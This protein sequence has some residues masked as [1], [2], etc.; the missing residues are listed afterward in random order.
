MSNAMK[1][2][3]RLMAV[4][5]I[6]LA[7]CDKNKPDTTPATLS[8]DA[9]AEITFNADGTGG[10][11]A[12]VVTTNQ[13][14]WDYTLAPA[15]G[16]GWL[17]AVKD[18]S[19]LKLTAAPNTQ[20]TAPSPVTITFRAGDAPEKTTT[21]KQLAAEEIPATLS[22]DAP[23]EITFNAD[24]TGEHS[25]ITVTTNQAEWNF[26]LT[27]EEGWLTAE[28]AG[29]TLSLT[30]APNT[31]PVTVEDVILEFTAGEAEPVTLTVKQE[32][33]APE[34]IF[35]EG[36]TFSMGSSLATNAP[37]NELPVRQVTLSDFSIGKFEVTQALWKAVL[38]DDASTSDRRGDDNLPIEKM[39]YSEV[40]EFL[41]AL[42][43]MTGKNYRLPTEAEWEYAAKGGK[44]K[45]AFLFSGSDNIDE[46]AW[47]M[48]NSGDSPTT[49]TTHPVGQKAPNS[50]GIYDMTGNVA[51]YVSDWYA[52]SYLP[53]DTDNP[54][55]P[56]MPT[57]VSNQKKVTRGGSYN[58]D[59]TISTGLGNQLTNTGRNSNW[60]TDYDTGQTYIGFRLVLPVTE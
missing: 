14:E 1:N 18:G 47:Y 34:M 46:V 29:N 11:S 21:V 26:T 54:Q 4:A 50:L 15:D 13:T 19:Q 52:A 49:T 59:A 31:L 6:V 32:M 38:G 57:M 60:A 41:A 27:P 8:I 56:A 17:T 39:R 51:E 25:E 5:A 45:D 22:T 43:E 58:S 16:A 28:K 35:V 9:P 33:G 12:V 30:A 55:G 3:F 42:N 20:S 53:D 10:V 24:G 40:E 7:S 23:G 2:L 48:G 37:T 36:G 44:N